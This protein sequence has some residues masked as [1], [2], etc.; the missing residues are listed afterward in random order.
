LGDDSYKMN[1]DS[2][3]FT[4]KDFTEK[5]KISSKWVSD[6]D[7]IFIDKNYDFI[8]INLKNN[9]VELTIYFDN[10]SEVKNIILEGVG[11]GEIRQWI[12][13]AKNEDG[14]KTKKELEEL[15]I[16]IE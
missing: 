3:D 9:L 8:D 12:K 1:E 14:S 10:Y 7:K 15:P 5:R 4:I 16:K 2:G 13:D 11:E 6:K